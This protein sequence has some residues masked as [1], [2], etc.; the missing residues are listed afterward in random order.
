VSLHRVIEAYSARC[1][2]CRTV[3][4][5]FALTDA[6]IRELGFDRWALVQPLW[7]RC[8]TKRLIRMDTFG[9]FADIF[10]ER[11]YYKDDPALLACQRT[12]KPFLWNQLRRL[13]PVR[14]KQEIILREAVQHDLRTGL[15]VPLGVIGEPPGCFSF[16]TSKSDRPSRWRQRAAMLIAVDAFHEA[17]RLHGFP[18]PVKTL[19]ELS[20]RKREVLELAAIGKTDPEIATILGLKPSS[21]ETYMAQ[22]R[23]LFGVYG[24][25]QL[26]NQAL[27]F[28]LIAFE[29]AISGF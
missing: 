13:I 18:G 10:I 2:R 1:G 23:Q 5:L 17:R 28:G 21:V 14:P 16:V 3:A 8:P 29:D 12:D 4:E 15:T 27:R 9:E 24:R 26:C 6:A 7:F 20:P 25:T 11:E 22:M 19:P